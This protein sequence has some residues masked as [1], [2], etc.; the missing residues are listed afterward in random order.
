MEGQLPRAPVGGVHPEALLA[1]PSPR[2]PPST[3]CPVLP[4]SRSTAAALHA[5]TRAARVAPGSPW[6]T[7]ISPSRSIPVPAV[8][9]WLLTKAETSSDSPG[10]SQWNTGVSSGCGPLSSALALGGSVWAQ[11]GPRLPGLRPEDSL[12]LSPGW[13][14]LDPSCF[15]GGASLFVWGKGCGRHTVLKCLPPPPSGDPV[16]VQMPAQPP[17]FLHHDSRPDLPEPSEAGQWDVPDP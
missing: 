4:R 11:A 9:S 12:R 16:G 7:V 8:F 6:W 3:R 13:T 14:S 1:F 2:S 5:F 15:C 10:G 17:G